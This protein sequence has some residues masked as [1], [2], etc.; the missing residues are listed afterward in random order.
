[1]ELYTILLEHLQAALEM[2]EVG[3]CLSLCL[4]TD[5]S[6][7]MMFKSGNCAGHGRCWSS[8]SGSLNH[9]CTVPAVW[10]RTLLSSKLALF[11]RNNVP[12]CSNSAMKG[13]NGINRIPRAQLALSKRPILVGVFSPTLPENGNKSSFRNV[14]FLLPKTSDGGRSPKTQ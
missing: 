7:S 14:V 3:V 12:P 5:Q 11:F 6:G 13:N 4:R 9:D 2:L 1:V 10:I 8:S